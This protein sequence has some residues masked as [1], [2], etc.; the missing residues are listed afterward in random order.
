[1]AQALAVVAMTMPLSEPELMS[2]LS[3]RGYTGETQEAMLAKVLVGR[4]GQLEL[5]M[6]EQDL[7]KAANMLAQADVYEEEAEKLEKENQALIEKA[8]LLGPDILKFSEKIAELEGE[9]AAWEWVPDWVPL[10][11]RAEIAE[12]K[13]KLEELTDKRKALDEQIEELEREIA[14]RPQR[15]V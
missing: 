13:E 7:E 1:M 4:Q 2:Y 8:Q 11:P 9:M 10:G 6:A 14:V 5:T 3:R 15:A 12:T